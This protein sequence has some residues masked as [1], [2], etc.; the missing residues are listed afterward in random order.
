[1]ITLPQPLDN[2][3]LLLTDGESIGRQGVLLIE[4]KVP[5]IEIGLAVATGSPSVVSEGES[6]IFRTFNA[7]HYFAGKNKYAI[8]PVRD[9]LAGVVAR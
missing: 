3:V 7:R 6:I 9:C 8:V 5:D 4:E 1:M 2:E